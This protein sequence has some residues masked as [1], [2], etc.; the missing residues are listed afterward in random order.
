MNQ[1]EDDA[2]AHVFDK[3]NKRKNR[4]QTKRTKTQAEQN[5]I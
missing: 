3:T 1:H 2:N 4:H 5:S